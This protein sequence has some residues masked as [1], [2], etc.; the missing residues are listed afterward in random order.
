MRL[1]LDDL[2]AVKGAGLLP[3]F[4]WALLV[5]FVVGAV[6]SGGLVW[7]WKEGQAAIEENAQLRMDAKAW[8][9][10][11]QAGRAE[12]VTQMAQLRQATQRLGEIS[13]GREDDREDLRQLVRAQAAALD[14]LRAAHPGWAGID[15]G[16]DFVRHW[17]QANSGRASATPAAAE[18]SGEPSP[19]VP[20]ASDAGRSP[21][22]P[23]PAA[24]RPGSGAVPG[25]QERQVPSGS[26][27]DRVGGHGLALVL[28]G[29]EGRRRA[30]EGLPE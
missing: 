12:S 22:D 26:G 8:Q 29:R 23:D 21:A 9:D 3:A 13:Q 11:A 10:A 28:P 4:G 5:A 1:K 2:V 14:A 19:A 25:L 27:G 20:A 30:G 16:P 15:L 6:V 24:A 18:H 7:K 17:N